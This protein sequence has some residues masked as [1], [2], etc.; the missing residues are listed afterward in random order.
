MAIYKEDVRV[1]ERTVSTIVID[2]IET[3]ISVTVGNQYRI[4]PSYAFYGMW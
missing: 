2:K 1:F 4:H 3:T